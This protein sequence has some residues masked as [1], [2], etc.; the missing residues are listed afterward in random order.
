MSAICTTFHSSWGK[1]E[2]F[3]PSCESLEVVITHAVQ[4]RLGI[5]LRGGDPLV[6]KEFLHLVQGHA[7]VQQDRSDAGAQSVRCDVLVDAGLTQVLE[8]KR[9]LRSDR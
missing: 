8:P 1:V 3:S 7:S 4:T 6:A 2:L 5:D 9:T